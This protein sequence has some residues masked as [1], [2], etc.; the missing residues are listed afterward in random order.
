MKSK[1]PYFGPLMMLSASILF[2]TGGILCKLV[3][4]SAL[5]INGT[6]NLLA[7]M[8]I[9]AYLLAIRHKLRFNLM[10]LF[11]AVC[12]CG[13]TTLFI[14]ANKLTTAGNTIILQYSAPIWII[15]MSFIFLHKKPVRRDVI[16]IVFVFIGII[17]FFLDSI[18][19]GN[20]LGNILALV[21]G[22]F[23]AGLFM[24]N[25]L[26]KADALSSLFLGQL[27]TGLIFTPFIVNETDFSAAPI[28]AVIALGLFQVGLAYIFF[29]LGTKLIPPVTASIINGLEPVLNPL[30]VMIFWKEMFTP[31][32]LIGAVI[33]LAT[34][35]IYNI[36]NARSAA[37][38]AA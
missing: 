36:I 3:P 7:S 35:L 13:V 28:M 32:S 16:A 8:V 1:P 21:S 14:M 38:N 34:I 11:G 6:R 37:K 5:A 15:L 4:W 18:G 2:S 27:G 25:S 33:V 22:I 24:L 9:G 20:T 12:M 29:N 10:I 19:A 17:F 26:P 31:L 23:Y 30:L